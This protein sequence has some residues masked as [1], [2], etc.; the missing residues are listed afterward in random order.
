MTDTE[1]RNKA[2]EIYG[3]LNGIA[4]KGLNYWH[5]GSLHFDL[6]TPNIFPS[7]DCLVIPIGDKYK[8][9]ITTPINIATTLIL[10]EVENIDGE[11]L[12]DSMVDIVKYL[13]DEWLEW[14]NNK[15]IWKL[16]RLS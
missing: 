5:T 16:V 14:T 12:H 2:N 10:Y 4:R 3:L 7:L 6:K 8:I 15:K 9:K 11:K 13:D 1:A